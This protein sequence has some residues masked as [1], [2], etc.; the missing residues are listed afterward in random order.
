MSFDELRKLLDGPSQNKK[1]AKLT[2]ADVAY[3][4]TLLKRWGTDYERMAKDVRLNRMQWTARQIEK[5]HEALKL[6]D[7]E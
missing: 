6:L 1:P 3:L 7:E 2:P 5:K 4:E